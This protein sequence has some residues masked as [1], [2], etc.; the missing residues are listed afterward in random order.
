MEAV[1][2]ITFQIAVFCYVTSVDL[3][4]NENKYSQSQTIHLIMLLRQLNE[5]CIT[6]RTF[7]CSVST[8]H[9]RG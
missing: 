1:R 8:V 3:I 5:L 9:Q 4:Q 6:V 7:F 2:Y